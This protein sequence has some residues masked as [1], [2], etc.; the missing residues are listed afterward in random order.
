MEAARVSFIDRTRLLRKLID[1]LGRQD[2]GVGDLAADGHR[3]LITL[4][5][6]RSV[7]RTHLPTA[8]LS[9]RWHAR[10]RLIKAII[11]FN[12]VVRRSGSPAGVVPLG[13][14]NTAR[15]ETRQPLLESVQVMPRV[16]GVSRRL[17]VV[18]WDCDGTL[19]ERSRS[20]LRMVAATARAA[21]VRLYRLHPAGLREAGAVLRE[22]L[23]QWR[24]ADDERAG[25]YEVARRLFRDGVDQERLAAAART[26]AGYYW[27]YRPVHGIVSVL[28]ELEA[29]GVR[30]AVL[31]NWPPSLR[32]FL[33]YHGLLRCFE[34]V[35]VSGEEGIVKPDPRI[36]EIALSRLRI[37]P[38]DAIFIGNDP[39]AD[40]A[41]AKRMG[42]TAIHF[43]PRRDH[44]GADARDA[45][46]LRALIRLRLARGTSAPV[47][48]PVSSSS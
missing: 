12:R 36:F 19:V 26:L 14:A 11:N 6:G 21:G 29:A 1:D 43:D 7:Y 9:D 30:Q 39:V 31:S 8:A 23:L 33:E 42:I 37:S 16:A 45:T 4:Q 34:T 5:K 3:V 27:V 47:T 24:T 10:A 2:I 15:T 46:V 28:Q 38:A 32:H 25:W 40:I 22:Q 20:D 44:P 41:P 18:I 48:V 17:P 13:P 35:V